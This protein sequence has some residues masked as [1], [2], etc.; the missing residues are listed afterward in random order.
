MGWDQVHDEAETLEHSIS[1]RLLAAIAAKLGDPVR[2]PHGDPI[3]SAELE[4]DEAEAVSL[5]RLPVGAKGRLVRILDASADLLAYLDRL[6]HLAGRRDRGGRAWSPSA[7]RSPCRLEAASAASAGS[8]R[9]ALG[10][11]SQP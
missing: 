4:I 2:D 8:P 9:R 7:A 5:D 1:D 11:E 6:G 10:V 3:P